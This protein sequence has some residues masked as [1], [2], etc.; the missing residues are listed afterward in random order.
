MTIQT[1]GHMVWMQ[2]QWEETIFG[3]MCVWPKTMEE[4]SKIM[5]S[6]YTKNYGGSLAD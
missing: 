4:E 5:E 6:Y 1:R 2:V 3:I